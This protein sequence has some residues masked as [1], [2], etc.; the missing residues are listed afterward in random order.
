M[1]CHFLTCFAVTM[2]ANKAGYNYL[3][4][5]FRESKGPATLQYLYKIIRR[6][7][8][9]GNILRL[10]SWLS[11]Q[12]DVV[13]PHE[14]L[15]VAE[16]CSSSDARSY[17]ILYNIAWSTWLNSLSPTLR[18]EWSCPSKHKSVKVEYAM[19]LHQHLSR[20]CISVVVANM[21][22]PAGCELRLTSILQSCNDLK[23]EAPT[24]HHSSCYRS[25]LCPSVWQLNKLWSRVCGGKSRI[26]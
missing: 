8:Y 17:I 24:H 23:E 2:C 15:D 7:S 13:S 10:S 19:R 16:L 3:W 1:S 14:Q 4:R 20:A 18:W 11:V 25:A 26:S 6:R 5:L 9:L 21:A 22:L 12:L